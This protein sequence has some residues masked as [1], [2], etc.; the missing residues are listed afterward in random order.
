MILEPAAGDLGTKRLVIVAEGALQYV[1]FAALSVPGVGYQPLILR[2]EV[3]SLPS[4]SAFAVQRENLAN[5]EP[6]PK[7]L[8]IH[9]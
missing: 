7:T 1:P 8:A 3:I 6:A 4:A 5:R 9:A 2:H